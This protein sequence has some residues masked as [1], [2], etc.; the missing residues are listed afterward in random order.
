MT[1]TF[2][3][4]WMEFFIAIF[5]IGTAA[6]GVALLVFM[7]RLIRADGWKRGLSLYTLPYR[8]MLWLTGPSDVRFFGPI[9]KDFDRA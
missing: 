3:F 4:M 2:S 6:V 9:P 5:A 8:M 7:Y 1:V